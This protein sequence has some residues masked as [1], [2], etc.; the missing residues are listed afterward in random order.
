MI[1]TLVSF[2]LIAV[3]VS[4]VPNLRQMFV[5]EAQVEPKKQPATQPPRRTPPNRP[6]LQPQRAPVTQPI[7]PSRRI[8]LNDN[9]SPK[10]VPKKRRPLFRSN[11]SIENQRWIAPLKYAHSDNKFFVDSVRPTHASIRISPA[12]G[13]LSPDRPTLV[14][15]QNMEGLAIS[16]RLD[17]GDEPGGISVIGEWTCPTD[18]NDD[19]PSRFV[20]CKRAGVFLRET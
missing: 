19:S 5:V 14:T 2:A 9:T 10:P 3:I 11:L 13:E 1:Q 8:P 4:R 20:G 6:D 15:F 7:A 16:L 18:K 12:S 17:K